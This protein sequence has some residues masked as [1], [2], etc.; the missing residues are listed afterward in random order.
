MSRQAETAQPRE[1]PALTDR[2]NARKEA[3]REAALRVV[4]NKGLAGLSMRAIATEAELPLGAL[5][6]YFK[7]KD[8]L[9][10]AAF[11][12]H[13]RREADRMLKAVM[14][15]GVNADAAEVA[16]KL[17]TFVQRGL[18]EER[19]SLV[20]EYEFLIESTRNPELARISRAWRQ[21]LQMQI[22]HIAARLGSDDPET[23]AEI[24]LSIVAGLEIDHLSTPPDPATRQAIRSA[25]SRTISKLWLRDEG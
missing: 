6:Y 12:L 16:E 11:E 14:G 23:D 19:T 5:G 24:I 7:T 17:A 13:T 15:V 1:T 4:G 18:T 3:I 20:A 21:A 2:G 10:L 22:S 8:D 9:I 25:L